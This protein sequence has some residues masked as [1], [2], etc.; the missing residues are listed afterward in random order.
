[1]IFANTVLRET[2]KLLPTNLAPS[3]IVHPHPQ[4]ALGETPFCLLNQKHLKSK[5]ETYRLVLTLL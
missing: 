1:M 3:F 4:N 2:A 5:Q